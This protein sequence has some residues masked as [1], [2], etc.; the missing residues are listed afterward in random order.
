MLQE[1]RKNAWEHYM[2]YTIQG[3]TQTFTD[4]L[5]NADL[6]SPFDPNC[7]KEVSEKAV[8]WLDRFDAA[9]LK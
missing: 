8:E 7:L 4:L 5:K 1:D 9:K 6:V 2:A 3:G